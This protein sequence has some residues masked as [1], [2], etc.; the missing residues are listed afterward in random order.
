MRGSKA[1]GV[2]ILFLLLDISRISLDIL[3]AVE[4][5]FMEIKVDGDTKLYNPVLSFYFSCVSSFFYQVVF[6]TV[7]GRLAQLSS[8]EW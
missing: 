3:Y 5:Y 4:S 1:L 8:D 6:I 2:I 7:I